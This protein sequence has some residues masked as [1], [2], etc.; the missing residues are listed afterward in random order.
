MFRGSKS[1]KL[2]VITPVLNN[3]ERPNTGLVEVQQAEVEWT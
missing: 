1:A 2:V 3:V